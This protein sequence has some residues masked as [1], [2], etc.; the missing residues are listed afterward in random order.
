MAF[1]ASLRCPLKLYAGDN[2]REV[3]APLAASAQRLNKDCELV[4]VPGDHLAMVRPAVQ[5]ALAW[6]REQSAK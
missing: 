5:Q 3:N 2:G 1:I 4:V 6:F